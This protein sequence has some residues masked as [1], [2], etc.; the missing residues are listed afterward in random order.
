MSKIQ[1]TYTAADGAEHTETREIDP[2][3]VQT[4]LAAIRPWT[5]TVADVVSVSTSDVFGYQAE[6]FEGFLIGVFLAWFFVLFFFADQVFADFGFGAQSFLERLFD[7]EVEH[8]AHFV[9][10]FVGGLHEFGIAVV[11]G[12]RSFGR[13]WRSGRG[14][15]LGRFLLGA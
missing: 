4:F 15:H 11:D 14:R 6:G 7:G 5:T 12:F 9:Q 2:S 8:V 3:L 13:G 1:V 10:N